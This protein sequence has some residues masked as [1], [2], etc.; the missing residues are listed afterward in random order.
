MKTQMVKSGIE[1]AV[2]PLFEEEVRS[3]GF[4]E[5]G[6]QPTVFLKEREQ[7]IANPQN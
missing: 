5:Y 1:T 7:Y 2:K 4:A 3:T 6:I